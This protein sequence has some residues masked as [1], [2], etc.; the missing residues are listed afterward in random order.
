MR[1]EW[2]KTDVSNVSTETDQVHVFWRS[3]E[4]IVKTLAPARHFP[5]ALL[6]RSTIQNV[7]E[8]AVQPCL[9]RNIIVF[10]AK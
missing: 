3:L 5:R 4:P 6:G 7:S 1:T 8:G 9:A 2:T 10:R